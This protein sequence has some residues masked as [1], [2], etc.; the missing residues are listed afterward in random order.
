MF[1][2]QVQA[3][4]SIASRERNAPSRRASVPIW[5]ATHFNAESHRNAAKK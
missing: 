5:G 2:A 3:L 4:P 1:R